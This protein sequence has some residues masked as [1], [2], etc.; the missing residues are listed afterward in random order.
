M[1]K[2]SDNI[3]NLVRDLLLRAIDARAS[4]VHFDP[5]DKHM[6]VRFRLNG[7]LEDVERLPVAVAPNI[8]AR[9][10]VLAG[11][12]TYR[13]DLP[14]EGGI[15]QKNSDFPCDLRVATF[16]TIRGERVVVR[17]MAHACRFITL[18]RLGY[19]P[20]LLDRLRRHLNRPQG[21]LLVCG[22]AGSGK[23]TT[24]YAC[25]DY[26]LRSRPGVS[27]ISVEDPVEIRLDGIT[28]IALAPERGLTYSVALRS[29]LRQDPQVLMIG[30]VRDAEVAAILIEAALTG[31]LV[32]SSMH[33][34]SCSE[35]IVRLRE[36]GIPPY[37]ITSTLQGVL[38]Q[39]LVR[40]RSA[41]VPENPVPKTGDEFPNS[42]GVD[43]A[44]FASRSA[45]G[46][47]VEMTPSLR[48][49]ILDGADACQLSSPDLCPGSLRADAQ[50]LLDAGLTATEELERVL[51]DKY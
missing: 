26:I 9:L 17:I 8:V 50:R 3:V 4:D 32:L 46:H 36:M 48:Q 39:R 21:L 16:P 29:L 5:G 35:A 20:D 25:L 15:P 42:A 6:N 2:P 43:S 47:F 33:G 49:A 14:Q 12:L 1:N 27:I 34:G 41:I 18:D 44:D 38:T 11:L 22:P 40:V 28:Q 23:T 7:I 24:L 31:H 19:D 13:S 30:E 10:K 37:Q 51:W 45:I